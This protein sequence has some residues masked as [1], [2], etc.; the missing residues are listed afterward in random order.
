MYTY[1]LLQQFSLLGFCLHAGIV[2]LL[3]F[4][5]TVLFVM[6]IALLGMKVSIL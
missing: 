5:I 6:F 1:I 3:T 4:V 2:I